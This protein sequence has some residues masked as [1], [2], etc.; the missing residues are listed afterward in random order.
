MP[1]KWGYKLYSVMLSLVGVAAGISISRSSVKLNE[2][3][4]IPSP[5]YGIA[6]AVLSLSAG[7]YLVTEGRKPKH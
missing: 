3:N 6:F 4:L 2:L 5:V 7:V 1:N